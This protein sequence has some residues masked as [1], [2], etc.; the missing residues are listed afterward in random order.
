MRDAGGNSPGQMFAKGKQQS[1]AQHEPRQDVQESLRGRLDQ[2][3]RAGR[4]V[5]STG[6][7]Q[8]NHD[9]QCNVELLRISTAARGGSY[10]KGQSVGS[11]G[12][13]WRNPGKQKSGKG[14]KAPAAG[15]SVDSAAEGAGKEQEDGGVQVQTQVLPRMRLV[16]QKSSAPLGPTKAAE[17]LEEP[18]SRQA[19]LC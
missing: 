6:Q 15:D 12:G 8:R 19:N 17:A 14:D 18:G 2:E 4:A 1:G 9:A 7:D 11:V 5:E 3:K 13:N 16:R 10:P